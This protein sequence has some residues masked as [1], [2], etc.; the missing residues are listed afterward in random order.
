MVRGEERRGEER[1]ERKQ[2][3]KWY[4]TGKMSK[5]SSCCEAEVAERMDS[6]DR[7]RDDNLNDDNF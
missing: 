5:A 2:Y 3:A 4:L 1:R 6:E 7:E